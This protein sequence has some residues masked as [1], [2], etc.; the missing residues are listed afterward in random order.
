MAA[1][2]V[3]LPDDKHARLK[4]L[5]KSRGT[6]LNRLIED[7]TTAML[8]DFDAETRFR[9]RVAQGAGTTERGLELL[10]QLDAH[11]SNEGHK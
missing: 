3:R 4:A 7:M 1:L 10:N 11:F 2:T 5:A 6:P 9:I 8:A